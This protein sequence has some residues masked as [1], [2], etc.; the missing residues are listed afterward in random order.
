MLVQCQSPGLI[1]PGLVSICVSPE[2]ICVGPMSSGLVS[3]CV[4][5]ESI[6]V[7]P[8]SIFWS[9]TTRSSFNLC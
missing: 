8:V 2:S 6:C 5:L 4:G 1:P 9:I 3:I 7:G